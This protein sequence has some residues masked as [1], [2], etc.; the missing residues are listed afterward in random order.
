MALLQSIPPVLWMLPKLYCPVLVMPD[1]GM[2]GFSA[3]FWWKMKE[4]SRVFSF[5]RFNTPNKH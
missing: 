2:I 1:Y 5:E 3:K 4:N